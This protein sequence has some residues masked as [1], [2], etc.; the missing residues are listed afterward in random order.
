MPRQDSFVNNHETVLLAQQKE[1]GMLY[2]FG[3]LPGTGKSTLSRHLACQLR[4]VHLRVDTIEQAL[5]EAGR[6]I[7]GPEGYNVAYHIAED[8][9]CLGLNVVADS[10]NP[11]QLT[12]TAWRAVAARAG[13]PFVEIEIVCSDQAE[14][15]TR[16]ETRSTNIAGF[17]LPTWNEVVSREYEPWNAKHILIDTAAQT[18][19]QSIATL[20]RSL[21]AK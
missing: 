6:Q 15:R 17:K 19:E 9:L 8:N 16:V 7:T 14:H 2:I 21:A 18:P 5:R 1:Q 20:E 3:G 10:V 4:A 12:R 11:L 13:V